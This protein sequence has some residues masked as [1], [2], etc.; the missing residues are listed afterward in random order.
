L[1]SSKLSTKKFN[2]WKKKKKKKKKEKVEEEVLLMK[3][4]QY[5]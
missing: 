3:F 2:A 1:R 4:G 5:L